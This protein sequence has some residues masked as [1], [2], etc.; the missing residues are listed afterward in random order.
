MKR[1]CIFVLAV[2]AFIPRVLAKDGAPTIKPDVMSAFVWGEESPS[3]A[4]SSTIQDP[5]TGNAIHAL[6]YN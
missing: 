4:F 3:G 5:L 1:A 6:S 2:F